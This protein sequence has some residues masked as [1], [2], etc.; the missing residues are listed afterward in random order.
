MEIGKPY[1]DQIKKN[2]EDTKDGILFNNE[3][4]NKRS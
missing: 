1:F 2:R 4:V 3:I